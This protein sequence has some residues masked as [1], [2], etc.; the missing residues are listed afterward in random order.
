MNPKNESN[1]FELSDALDADGCPS[2]QF[3]A[4]NHWVTR[5]SPDFPLRQQ[6]EWICKIASDE[7]DGLLDA[8]HI[9]GPEIVGPVKISADPQGV[10]QFLV[11]HA[12]AAVLL[13]AGEELCFYK[14]ASDRFSVYMG[15]EAAVAAAYKLPPLDADREFLQWIDDAMFIEAE[16]IALLKIFERYRSGARPG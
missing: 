4:D 15:S 2:S 11:Q 16:R 1:D 3:I 8:I 6:I 5:I 13:R 10:M 9:D 7:R 12:Y 14:D